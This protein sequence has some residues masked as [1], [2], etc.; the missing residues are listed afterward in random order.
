[1][2]EVGEMGAAQEERA[3]GKV[4]GKG[5]ECG[6]LWEVWRE[7]FYGGGGAPG[8]EG[9]TREE[10]FCNLVPLQLKLFIT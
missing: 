3:C 1:M 8:E 6:A 4:Y 10:G 2:E 7:G 5:G 9:G